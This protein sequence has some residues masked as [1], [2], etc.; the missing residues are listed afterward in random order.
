MP[1]SKTDPLI[2][3]IL[4][5]SKAEKRNFKLYVKKIQQEGALKFLQLFDLLEKN[6]QTVE[7]VLLQKL[8]LETKS[9]LSS[10]KRH[11]FQHVLTSLR[12]LYNNKSLDIRIREL[13]DFATILYRKNLY[14]EALQ[15]LNKAKQLAR[16]SHKDHLHLEIVEFEKRIESRHITRTSTQRIYAL[17]DE[18]QS[19]KKVISNVTDLSNLKLRLQRRF[20]NQGH[21][22]QE[23]DQQELILLFNNS[24]PANLLNEPTFFERV[25][26]NQSYFWLHYCM[27]DFDSCFTY[28]KKWVDLFKAEPEMINK[29]LE[30]YL[31]GLHYLLVI[32]FCR[33]DK[34]TFIK[35]FKDLEKCGQVLQIDWTQ[36]TETQYVFFKINAKLN[37]YLLL[38]N[39][40]HPADTISQI[41]ESLDQIQVRIDPH[42]MMIL[43]YKIAHLYFRNGQ[44]DKAIDILNQILNHPGKR[45]RDDLELYTRLSL[46]MAHYDQH[47]DIVADYLLNTTQRFFQKLPELNQTPKLILQ[48]LRKVMQLD[49]RRAREEMQSCMEQ[50]ES[51]AQNPYEKR[52]FVFLDIRPWLKSHIQQKSLLEIMADAY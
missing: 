19:R 24:L 27:L 8:E 20:I 11:L 30:I 41:V 28:A 39:T 33:R 36:I 7:P 17:T 25:Y 44:T 13:T 3:L 26:L 10:V 9:Q 42:K 34:D 29:D 1:I 51:L 23:K 21:T 45:L 4:S 15:L 52:A 2:R 6:N 48:L 12:L 38:P 43:Q 31:R 32:A 22:K 47:N 50:I 14:I 16:K 18:A 46:I 37:Y 5:L 35:V 49:P 40:D